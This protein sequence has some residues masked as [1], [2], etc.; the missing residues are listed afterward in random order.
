VHLKISQFGADANKMN[1]LYWTV[2]GSS[3][4]MLEILLD[5]GADP[6]IPNQVESLVFLYVIL[7]LTNIQINNY[8]FLL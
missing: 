1:I 3:K 7:L 8:C 6:N 4:E 5:G 2:Y